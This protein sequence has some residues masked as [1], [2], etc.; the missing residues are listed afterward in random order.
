MEYEMSKEMHIEILKRGVNHWNRWRTQNLNIVPELSDTD[1]HEYYLRDVNLSGAN[2][3]G[4]NLSK[5]DLRDA[6]L[7]KADLRGA[8]LLKANLTLA[9]LSEADL[10]EAILVEANLRLVRLFK[11]DLSMANL[12]KAYIYNANLQWANL[13]TAKLDEANLSKS[14]CQGAI[15]TKTNLMGAALIK[16]N[17]SESDFSGAN[18]N[19][20]NL[21]GWIIR[22][23][24]CTHIFWQGKQ[25]EFK[26]GEFERAFTVLENTIDIILD[27]PFSEIGYHTGRIIEEAIN[28]TYGEGS[29]LFK[30]QSAISDDSTRFEMISFVAKEEFE[31]IKARLDRL[32]SE[33]E[34]KVFKKYKEEITDVDERRLF[35][36]KDAIDVPFTGGMIQVSTK[37]IQRRVSERYMTMHPV[38]QQI[39]MVVQS[40]FQ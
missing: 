11:A 34:E 5:T 6:N 8:N 21:S 37:E 32:P 33:M 12:R 36:L 31:E 9:D 1:L 28:Q 30:G 4:A 39:A 2:L 27:L 15:L 23:I 18:L 19:N 13:F 29:V 10:R 17:F 25:L 38:L 14:I 22:R 7:R 24:K 26:E 40:A 20:A 16:A 3:K 35:R